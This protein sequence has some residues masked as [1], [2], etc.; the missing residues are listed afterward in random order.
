MSDRGNYRILEIDFSYD[1][2]NNDLTD[3][4]LIT[5]YRSGQSRSAGNGYSVLGF[6]LSNLEGGTR[7]D[8]G[9]T[10]L[11]SNEV[12][13]FLPEQNIPFNVIVLDMAVAA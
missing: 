10:D 3:V 2:T 6:E 9:G 4:D 11:A 8:T 13:I 7:Q 5:L 1:S 12:W